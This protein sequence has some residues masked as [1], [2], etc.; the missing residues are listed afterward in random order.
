MKGTRDAEQAAMSGWLRRRNL[1]QIV[2][3][4]DDFPD[5]EGT[6]PTHN[7]RTGE[8]YIPFHYCREDWE[9]SL[10]PLGLLRPLV[11]SEIRAHVELAESEDFEY[12][13]EAEI[14]PDG[15]SEQVVKAVFFAESIRY[16]S[17]MEPKA[18]TKVMGDLVEKWRGEGKFSDILGRE[19]HCIHTITG[20]N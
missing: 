4:A 8:Q 13:E 15:R 11:L 6:Y 3:A 10:Q 19:L 14:G 2:R 12:V 20:A 1:L 7:R 17:Y 9:R 5:H 16:G 18:S